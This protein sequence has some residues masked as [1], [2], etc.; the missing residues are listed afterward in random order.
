[1]MVRKKSI[2]W[3]LFEPSFSIG[4]WLC[5]SAVLLCGLTSEIGWGQHH[6]T[7]GRRRLAAEPLFIITKPVSPCWHN[8][9]CSN[10]CTRFAARTAVIQG[11]CAGSIKH[12]D[13][14][15]VL[16]NFCRQS[17]HRE[18]RKQLFCS[19]KHEFWMKNE[20]FLHIFFGPFTYR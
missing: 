15:H 1:M 16:F 3:T 2:V 18:R 8:N 7:R 4:N 6:A 11:S 19:E 10:Y 17:I 20:W 14:L 12:Y 13:F 9:W 5:T